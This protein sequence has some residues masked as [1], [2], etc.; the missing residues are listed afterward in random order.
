MPVGILPSIG[1]IKTIYYLFIDGN[2]GAL[3]RGKAR[4]RQQIA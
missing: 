2:G 3:L 4:V 1:N